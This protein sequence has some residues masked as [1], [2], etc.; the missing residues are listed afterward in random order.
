MKRKEMNARNG[1]VQIHAATQRSLFWLFFFHLSVVITS[2]KGTDEGNRRQISS[3]V[4]QDDE[5][6]LAPRASRIS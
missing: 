3:H 4:E 5:D 1:A 6:R 2:Y